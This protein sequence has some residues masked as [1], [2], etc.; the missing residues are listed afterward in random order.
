MIEEQGGAPLVDETLTVEIKGK[1][2]QNM[3][4]LFFL[5]QQGFF[6]LSA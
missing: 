6:C 4:V 2:I 3:V 1:F 5:R